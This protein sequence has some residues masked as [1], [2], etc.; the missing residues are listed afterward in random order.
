MNKLSAVLATILLV[1]GSCVAGLAFTSETFYHGQT[2]FEYTHAYAGDTIVSGQV[3]SFAPNTY[4]SFFT[5][6]LHDTGS[7]VIRAA[8]ENDSYVVGIAVSDAN[9]EGL[10]RI[11]I[12]GIV[13][14]K[15]DCVDSGVFRG[16]IA[17]DA[18][19]ASD[20]DGFLGGN[21]MN[22]TSSTGVNGDTATDYQRINT[23]GIILEPGTDLDSGALTT[24]LIKL[25]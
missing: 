11:Q 20:R 6:G 5:D 3:V 23:V 24:Y 19:S 17:G 10:V 13:E 25:R 16:L 2:D 18:L 21:E 12:R 4:N 1:F 8:A 22:Y 15:V 14:A 9:P 7:W